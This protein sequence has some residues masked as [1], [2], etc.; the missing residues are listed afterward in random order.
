MKTWKSKKTVC[1]SRRS[2]RFVRRR[3]CGQFKRQRIGLAKLGNLFT[4]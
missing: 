3:K 1:R 2:G 4:L